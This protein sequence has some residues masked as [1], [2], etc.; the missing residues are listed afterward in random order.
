MEKVYDPLKVTVTADGR[1]ITG[2]SDGAM[3][4][5]TLNDDIATLHKGAQ[6]DITYSENACRD[7]TATVTLNNSSDS[8]S[9]LNELARTRKRFAFSVTDANDDTS[10]SA[11]ATNCRILKPAD[12][13]RSKESE[14]VEI[15]ITIPRWNF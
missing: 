10:A 7:A 11:T 9:F 6:G 13:N 12:L 14:N 4:V 8:I 3:V 1:A 5:V 2:F 15:T